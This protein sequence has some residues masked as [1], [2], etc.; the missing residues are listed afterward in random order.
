MS[1]WNCSDIRMSESLCPTINILGVQ[2]DTVSLDGLIQGGERFIG[3]RKRHYV[4]YAN[5]HVL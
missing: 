5:V 1:F 4:M 3:A 2:V